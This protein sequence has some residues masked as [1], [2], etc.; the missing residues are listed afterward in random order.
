MNS[1]AA[2]AAWVTYLKQHFI[3][4]HEVVDLYDNTDI[5]I[6]VFDSIK[7]PDRRTEAS[8]Y[9]YKNHLEFRIYYTVT[10]S[11]WVKKNTSRQSELFGLLN[12]INAKVWPCGSDGVGDS[13]HL[14]AP[15]LYMTEDG[16]HDITMT[17]IIPYDFYEVAPLQ[18]EDFLIAS[19]PEV[20]D[21]LSPA[22]FLLLLGKIDLN[23]AKRIVDRDV[24]GEE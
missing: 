22:I 12:Y 18:T 15:R 7:S 9:F 23:Q 3:R 2:K 16:C 14:Y 21:A 1:K 13:I 8:I 20:M 5:I 11:N 17:V 10:A 6:M 19:L 4:Y 24:L